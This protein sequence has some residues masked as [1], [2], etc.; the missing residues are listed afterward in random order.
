M[1]SR[2]SKAPRPTRGSAS[3][4]PRPLPPPPTASALREHALATLARRPLTRAGL[5]Q[6]LERKIGAWA[7]RAA[8]LGRDQDSITADVERARLLVETVAARIIEV[9]LVN[10]ESFAQARAGR[11]AR[12]GKSRRAI[13]AHLASKGV[14]EQTVRAAV[15]VDAETEL[16]AALVLAR[17]K[18]LGPF[19]RDDAER[20]HETR[21]KALAT[22]ARAGFGFGTAERVLRMGPDEAEELMRGRGV[23]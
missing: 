18:R 13:G 21:H 23:L 4:R 7:Q 20:T 22:L 2:F 8:R 19:A 3:P 9:G 17:R 16:R 5:R 10:D 15:P 14:D 6:T 11:L 1:A 12:A